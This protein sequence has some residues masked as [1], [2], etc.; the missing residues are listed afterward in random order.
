MRNSF[1]Y[2]TTGE[3]E[4]NAFRNKKHILLTHYFLEVYAQQCFGKWLFLFGAKPN[5]SSLAIGTYKKKRK[6][7]FNLNIKFFISGNAL[8]YILAHYYDVIMS[9][10]ASQIT[11]LTIVYSIVYSGTD[12][13]KH[14]SSASL[15]FVPGIHQRQVNSPHKWPVTQKMYPFDYVIM[16]IG[17]FTSF[18]GQATGL[19]AWASR[20]KC[21]ARFVSHLHDI[22]IYMSCL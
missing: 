13:R 16:L 1:V 8:E 4:D 14:Q 12:Q 9:P 17:F 22:C 18:M 15:S 10:T 2:S 6:W 11:S 7:I 21:P 3:C 5:A 20:V 19:D